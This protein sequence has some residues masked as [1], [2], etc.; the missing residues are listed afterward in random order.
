MAD[1]VRVLR[2]CLKHV[3]RVYSPP[4]GQIWSQSKPVPLRPAWGGSQPAPQ[5]TLRACECRSWQ[6]TRAIV[7]ERG[8]IACTAGIVLT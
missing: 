1:E 7:P 5:D 3:N 4:H 2:C 6:P 8:I